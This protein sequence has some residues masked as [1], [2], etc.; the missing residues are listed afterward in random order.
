MMTIPETAARAGRSQETI[1]R[2]VRSGK[3]PARRIGNQHIV[4]EADLDS[5]S[6]GDSL[7]VPEPWRPTFDGSPMPDVVAAVRRSRLGH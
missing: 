1:R 2:W 7:P 6:R 3:L 5:V 4:D